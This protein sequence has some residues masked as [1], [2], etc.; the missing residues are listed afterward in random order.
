MSSPYRYSFIF[1]LQEFAQELV[2]L[3]DAMSRIYNIEREQAARGNWVCRVIVDS[4]NSNQIAAR[5]YWRV[6]TRPG[7][8][9][10]NLQKRLCLSASSSGAPK[11]P[12]HFRVSFSYYYDVSRETQE[13]ILPKGPTPCAQYNAHAS[14]LKFTFLGPTQA[15][16][17]G[18]WGTHP[19]TR[20]EAC[21]QSRDGNGDTGS[22]RVFRHD[23]RRIHGI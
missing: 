5:R 12:E 17:L 13:A 7:R 22:A 15:E 8:Q 2:S 1:T 19:R 20:H 10:P 18:L 23:E 21:I 11:D 6:N 3:V 16:A 14:P 9:R 4:Y